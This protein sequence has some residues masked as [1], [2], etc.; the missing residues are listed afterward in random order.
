MNNQTEIQ[1]LIDNDFITK[2]IEIVKNATRSINI[3][4]YAWR[5]YENAPEKQ[6]QQ[7][8]TLLVQKARAGVTVN[9]IL[10]Q[11]S[12]ALKI[13]GYG[14]TTKTYPTDRAMHTKAI[15][16][17][18]GTLIIGSHNLT[19]R[20][21]AENYETSILTTDKETCYQFADYFRRMWQNYAG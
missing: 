6:I 18:D 10:D 15:L 17:D 20:G 2:A 16:V 3:C 19:E 9:A 14:I 5:W 12:Q 4:A 1:L 21:T 7:L 8:N 13:S 11:R